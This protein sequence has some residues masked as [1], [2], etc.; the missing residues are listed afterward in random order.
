MV[1]W[2][3]RWWEPLLRTRRFL[4]PFQLHMESASPAW[5]FFS[6]PPNRNADKR[7][8][9]CVTS[10]W[11]SCF[12]SP[13]GTAASPFHRNLRHQI[14]ISNQIARKKILNISES[15]RG[16]FLHRSQSRGAKLR[17]LTSSFFIYSI[18]G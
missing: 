6:F 13:A 9:V 17:P 8:L 18:Y 10:L 15:G 16:L 7:P 5:G 4:L 1:R 12:P 3:E 14:R 11:T 2:W